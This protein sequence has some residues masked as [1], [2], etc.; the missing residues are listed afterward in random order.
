MLWQKKPKIKCVVCGRLTDYGNVC[1][2]DMR[3]Y[4]A[5]ESIRASVDSQLGAGDSMGD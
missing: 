5:S 1:I 3:E 2:E 4:L